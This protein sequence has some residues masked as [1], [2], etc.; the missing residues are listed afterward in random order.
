MTE[1]DPAIEMDAMNAARTVAARW[2]I[3][4][5]DRILH[6]YR[7][8]LLPAHERAVR[9]QIAKDIKDFAKEAAKT[10]D[11]AAIIG[12]FAAAKMAEGK[13]YDSVD[14]LADALD[15]TQWARPF[16]IIYPRRQTVHG[17]QM[18]NGVCVTASGYITKTAIRFED[19]VIDLDAVVEWADGGQP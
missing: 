19:M 7:N 18:P 8:V 4:L 1:L 12:L 3:L 11:P 2:K 15:A 17:V 9:E 6:A 16:R 10:D 13:H 5:D 14:D